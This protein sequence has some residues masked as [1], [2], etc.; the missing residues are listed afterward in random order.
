ME[1]QGAINAVLAGEPYEIKIYLKIISHSLHLWQGFHILDLKK[2]NNRYHYHEQKAIRRVFE[3]T[4]VFEETNI[5][6]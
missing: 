2:L 5:S 4:S 6:S 1:S 3:E